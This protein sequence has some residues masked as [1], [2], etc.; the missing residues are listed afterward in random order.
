ML[1]V[2]L[3]TYSSRMFFQLVQTTRHFQTH[4]HVYS[5]KLPRSE[6]TY[7][8]EWGGG[9]FHA[10]IID[11]SIDVKAYDLVNTSRR[12]CTCERSIVYRYWHIV[13]LILFTFFRYIRCYLLERVSAFFDLG[14]FGLD[15]QPLSFS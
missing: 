1:Q 3:S 12:H 4:L 10:K 15:V 14:M 6:L 7:L 13:L 11:R 8:K 9:D 5:R 2:Y